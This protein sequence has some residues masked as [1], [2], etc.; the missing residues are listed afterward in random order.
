MVITD[1]TSITS[2][3]LDK[4]LKH[5]HTDYNPHSLNDCMNN[6]LVEVLFFYTIIDANE[7]TKNTNIL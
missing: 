2:I 3:K 7:W 6:Y 4:Q 1:A 5:K